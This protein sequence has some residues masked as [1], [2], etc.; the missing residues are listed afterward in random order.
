[1]IIHHERNQLA[2]QIGVPSPGRNAFAPGGRDR[3]GFPLL[4][5]LWGAVRRLG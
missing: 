2:K 3:A 4:L 5:N 1:M